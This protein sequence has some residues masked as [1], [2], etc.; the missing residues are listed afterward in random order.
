MNKRGVNIEKDFQLK[1]LGAP[2]IIAVLEKGEVEG[3]ILWESHVSRLLATGRYR[4]IMALREEL[5]KLLNTKVKT[6]GWVGAL[7]AWVKQNPEMISK[8]RGAWQEG[9]R[10]VQEDE[11]HFRKYAKEMFGLE[12]PHDVALGWKR[13]R[14][15]LLPPDFKWPDASNLEAEKTYLKE[16]A[17][18]GMFPKE[19]VRVIDPMFVP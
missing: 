11:P 8:L 7:D 17:E 15:F 10:G 4:I 16:G 13:T 14:T 2:G 18:M 3:A 19:A 9:I 1:K 12:Q 5:A 6:M